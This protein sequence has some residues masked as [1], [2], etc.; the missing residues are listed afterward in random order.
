MHRRQ[1]L[2]G[3]TGV[4]GA[5]ALAIAPAAPAQ[6]STAFPTRPIRLVIAFP[7]GGP[8]RKSVV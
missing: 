2:Q 4:L 8:D 3:A 7:A 5:A 1:L 6:T